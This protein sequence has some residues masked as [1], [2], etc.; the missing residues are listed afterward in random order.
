[1]SPLKLSRT[2]ESAFTRYKL[3]TEALSG[4]KD[5]PKQLEAGCKTQSSF[6]ALVVRS[7][8]VEKVALNT[9]KASADHCIEAGGWRRLDAMRRSYK[10]SSR[11]TRKPTNSRAAKSDAEA[12]ALERRVRL[13]L[14][15]AYLDLLVHLTKLASEHSELADF[16]RRHQAGFSIDRVKLVTGGRADEQQ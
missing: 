12:L 16:L 11:V 9:L 14:E 6:A 8:G 15:T 13:R 2:N 5:I 10:A 4:G 1:M 7:H 3:L